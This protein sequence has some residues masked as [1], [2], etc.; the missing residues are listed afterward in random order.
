[1]AS[2]ARV[3]DHAPRP[4][5]VCITD[6]CDSPAICAGF[7]AACYAGFRRLR[8]LTMPQLSQY[9]KKIRRLNVRA[10]SMIG[11]AAPPPVIQIRNAP[12]RRH[13]NGHSHL[14]RVR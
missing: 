4:K 14:R 1:M 10:S 3:H 2:T 11:A 13:G 7:C 5:G 12:H 9:Y 6:G 8:D